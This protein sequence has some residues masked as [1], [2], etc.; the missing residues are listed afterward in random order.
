MD[1][2]IFW[3]KMDGAARLFARARGEVQRVPGS[4]STAEGYEG[5]RRQK[6]RFE[7]ADNSAAGFMEL[8]KGCIPARKELFEAL[9]N[10]PDV[11]SVE[12]NKN[13]HCHVHDQDANPWADLS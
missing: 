9:Q 6:Q 13:R 11:E 5:S 3:M 4:A 1:V 2:D 12:N 7:Y 10:A 8:H